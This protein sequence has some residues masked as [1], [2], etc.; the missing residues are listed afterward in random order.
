MGLSLQQHVR[1]VADALG[2]RVDFYR[3]WYAEHTFL[4]TVEGG[5]HNAFVSATAALEPSAVPAIARNLDWL[6]RFVNP[7][8]LSKAARYA[9]GGFSASG[10]LFVHLT[11]GLPTFANALLGEGPELVVEGA[12][13]AIVEARTLLIDYTHGRAPRAP[14]AAAREAGLKLGALV[15]FGAG[16]HA[17][18]RGIGGGMNAAAESL[19]AARPLAMAE[20]GV[21]VAAGEGA[22]ALGPWWDLA[23][24]GLLLQS[25]AGGGK[26]S[27]IEA[28]VDRGARS[29]GRRGKALPANDAIA[30][31][32]KRHEGNFERAGKELDVSA[33]MIRYRVR[34]A[35]EGTPLAAFRKLPPRKAGRPR[36]VSDQ[37]LAELLDRHGVDCSAVAQAIDL[38]PGS[39][40]QRVSSAPPSSPLARFQKHLSGRQFSQ[41]WTD[42][43]IAAAL[44]QHGGN[45][46]AAAKALGYASES[47]ARRIRV[48]EPDSPLIAFRAAPKSKCAA[49]SIDEIVEM[50][51]QY[52]GDVPAAAEALGYADTGTILSRIRRAERGSPLSHYRQPHDALAK[53]V[54]AIGTSEEGHAAVKAMRVQKGSLPRAVRPSAPVPAPRPNP[55]VRAPVRFRIVGE[56]EMLAR[57]R[58][59]ET[60]QLAQRR[61]GRLGGELDFDGKVFRRRVAAEEIVRLRAMSDE[62]IAAALARH[63]GAFLATAQEL[64]CTMDALAMRILEGAL[65]SPLK[66]YW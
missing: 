26:G 65:D 42:A 10:T 53:R 63:D 55:A 47:V 25:A 34:N 27:A 1:L 58:E 15:L 20:G 52:G 4:E 54:A 41:R 44:E 62:A 9:A 49:A 60:M 28:A 22:M 57:A 45:R 18:L 11:A 31:A 19:A 29:S 66:S 2:D 30:E 12:R 5:L 17:G 13:H 36:T 59:G 16:V 50:L 51:D 38:Q 8:V 40:R 7:I 6:D 21:V 61:R 32:L 33:A 35:P 37:E 23:R 43:E 56:G 39:V 48:A 64:Q 46:R 14:Y 3:D 24:G